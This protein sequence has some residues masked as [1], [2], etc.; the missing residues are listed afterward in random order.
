MR[1]AERVAD[2][3]GIVDILPRAAA[4]RP[5]HRLAMV[6]ELKRH[7]NDLGAR[8]RRKMRDHA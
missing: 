8:G 2:G 1:D 5:R 6:V 4:A 7:A 3:L